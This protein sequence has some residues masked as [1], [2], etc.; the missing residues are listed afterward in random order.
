MRTFLLYLSLLRVPIFFFGVGVL[1]S[2]HPKGLR[3]ALRGAFDARLI[4]VP[5]VM[6][7]VF[8][9]SFTL[10]L[11]AV[12]VLEGAPARMGAPPLGGW[13]SDTFLFSVFAFREVPV[14]KVWVLIAGI[15]LLPTVLCALRLGRA[16]K[17]RRWAK[18]AL[19]LATLGALILMCLAT[20]AQYWGFEWVKRVLTHL[21]RFDPQ[22]YIDPQTGV[23]GDLHFYTAQSLLILAQLAGYLGFV[24]VQIRRRKPV[25]KWLLTWDSFPILYSVYAMLGLLCLLLSALA[26]FLDRYGISLILVLI[27]WRLIVWYFDSGATVGYFWPPKSLP[28]PREVLAA[29]SAESGGRVIVV[30]ASGGGI[31]AAAWTTKVLTGLEKLHRGTFAALVRVLSGVSGGSVGVMN[32]AGVYAPITG[33]ISDELLNYPNHLARMSSLPAALGGWFLFDLPR[34][35]I[36]WLPSWLNRGWALERRWDID[37]YNNFPLGGWA[38]QAWF[39]R[40]PAVL[41]NCTAVESGRPVVFGTSALRPRVNPSRLDRSDRGY[42][43]SFHELTGYKVDVA[44]PTAARLSATFPFVS[45]ASR[46]HQAAKVT[47]D[48]SYVDGGYYDNFGVTTA[49]EFLHHALSDTQDDKNALTEEGSRLLAKLTPPVPIRKVLL[50]EIRAAASAS[51]LLLTLGKKRVLFAEQDHDP[52]DER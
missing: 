33:Q 30:C 4:A 17:S 23:V 44:V 2:W 34:L 45:P 18:V 8:A 47:P 37:G 46:I 24:L 21:C 36:P 14:K 50:I 11:C 15:A 5:T 39:G 10:W 49:L 12:T 41:F 40:R 35:F 3:S 31:H 28:T 6:I 19:C 27:I 9:Y 43:P 26:F 52:G 13:F 38:V 48:F 7:A 16:N 42:S 22:G 25:P 1:L 29:N 51:S 32:F 20:P